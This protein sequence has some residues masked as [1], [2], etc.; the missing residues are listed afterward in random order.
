MTK[1]SVVAALI[2]CAVALVLFWPTPYL[3]SPRWDVV[4][5][6]GAGQPLEG[7]SVR[8][9]FQN[10]SAEGTSHEITFT[11]DKS[12]HAVFEPQR[13]RATLI[14][15]SYYTAS[16]A[17]AGVHASFGPHAGVFAFGNGLEGDAVAGGYV[18]D[19]RGS[20][21]SMQSRIVVSRR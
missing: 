10:Y 4:V 13:R 16:S 17:M 5:V 12:G 3:A 20:P 8:L 11:T 15:R 2:L 14:Q 7:M 1:P 6:D 19:W 18:V 21:A 9:S